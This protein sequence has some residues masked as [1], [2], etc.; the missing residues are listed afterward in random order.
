MIHYGNML[1]LFPPFLY[2]VKQGGGEGVLSRLSYTHLGDLLDLISPH[3]HTQDTPGDEV[4]YFPPPYQRFSY[5]LQSN[6]HYHHHYREQRQANRSQSKDST[7]QSTNS[8]THSITTC[9]LASI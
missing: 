5:Q 4:R 3:A 1:S 9:L 8:L 6:H 7:N 2:L